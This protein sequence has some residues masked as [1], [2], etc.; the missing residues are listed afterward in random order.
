[1]GRVIGPPF[2]NLSTQHA[3]KPIFSISLLNITVGTIPIFFLREK[4]IRIGDNAD[5]K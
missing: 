5:N 2:V 1:M 4:K 3:L